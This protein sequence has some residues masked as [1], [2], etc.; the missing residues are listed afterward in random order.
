MNNL[1]ERH[2]SKNLSFSRDF[3][4]MRERQNRLL[5]G[6]AGCSLDLIGLVVLS[7]SIGQVIAHIVVVIFVLH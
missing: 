6:L 4:R 1:S 3:V 5:L 2:M 7:L